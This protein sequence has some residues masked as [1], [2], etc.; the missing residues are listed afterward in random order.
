MVPET[1]R[2][3]L[4]F[5]GTRNLRFLCVFDFLA[6]QFFL[7]GKRTPRFRVRRFLCYNSGG[8]NLI[9]FALMLLISDLQPLKQLLYS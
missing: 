1:I 7:S 9:R 4:N 3:S 5:F 2:N 6:P 8:L